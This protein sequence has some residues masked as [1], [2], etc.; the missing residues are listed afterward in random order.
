MAKEKEGR[1]GEKRKEKEEEREELKDFFVKYSRIIGLLSFALVIVLLFSTPSMILAKGIKTIDTELSQATEDAM[2]VQTLQDFGNNEHMLAFPKQIDEWNALEP[3]YNTTGVAETLGADVMLMRAY[4]QPKSYYSID[5]LILQ[6]NARSSFH[7]PIVCY[8][9][10]GYEIEEVGKE[11]VFVQNVSWAKSPLY[12]CLE[13]RKGELGYFNGTVSVK[14]LVVVKR[15]GESGNVTDRRVVLY[16]YV[17]EEPFHSANFTM[18]RVSALAPPEGSYDG[19]LN[20]TK[21]FLGDVFPYLF[22][23]QREE[24]PVFFILFNSG[25]VVGKIV[26]GVLFLVPLAIFFYPRIRKMRE[27]FL[28]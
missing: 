15:G 19:I 20:V 14:K 2:F 24:E 3:D 28:P 21:E 23:M 5:F 26:I 7:S 11:E 18:I 27:A 6:S 13:S 10:L 22:E 9:A 16:F 1:E 12:S 4:S 8:P 25:S 17:K